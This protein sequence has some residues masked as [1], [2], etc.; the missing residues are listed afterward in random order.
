M[1][2]NAYLQLTNLNFYQPVAII[3]TALSSFYYTSIK[4]SYL[5]RLFSR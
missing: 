4:T 3:V 2:F 1:L 5:D